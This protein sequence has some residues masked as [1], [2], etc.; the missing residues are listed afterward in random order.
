MSM[1]LA[2]LW[3]GIALGMETPSQTQPASRPGKFVDLLVS[4]IAGSAP[5]PVPGLHPDLVTGLFVEVFLGQA[6]VQR[7]PGSV[8]AEIARWPI[9]Q[10]VV[11]TFTD[12]MADISMT[13][14]VEYL[15]FSLKLDVGSSAILEEL[16]GMG[17]KLNET[18]AQIG[19][20]YARASGT[21]LQQREEVGYSCCKK[22]VLVCVWIT[23]HAINMLIAGTLLR[24]SR[25]SQLLCTAAFGI[26][27][28][29]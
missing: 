19:Y 29:T 2:M 20:A 23:P 10:S 22:H 13:S 27:F 24:K 6:V 25:K 16:L 1:M 3:W 18:H 7:S 14:S 5:A 26:R 12:T 11:A 9:P 28:S 21:L 17:R 8:R 4:E 15:L